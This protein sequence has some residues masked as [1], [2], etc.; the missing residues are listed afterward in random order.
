MVAARLTKELGAILLYTRQT[1][2]DEA[3]VLD[4]DEWATI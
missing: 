3:R 2:G 4:K 1:D